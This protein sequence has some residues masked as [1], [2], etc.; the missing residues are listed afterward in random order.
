MKTMHQMILATGLLAASFAFGAKSQEQVYV[1]S[2][3]GRADTPVPVTVVMPAVDAEHAGQTVVLEFTVGATG[4]PADIIVRGEH[5]AGLVKPLI[6]AVAQ[7]RF[8]PLRRDGV[9]VPA[10]VALPMT[11]VGPFDRAGLLANR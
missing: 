2:Y 7:W 5:P 11:I 10:R 4:A 9:A 1:E 3:R 8:A 6:A